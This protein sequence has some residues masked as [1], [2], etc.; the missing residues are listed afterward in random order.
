MKQQLEQLLNSAIGQ[1][2]SSDLLPGDFSPRFT[3]ERTRDPSHGDL[4]SNIALVSA[5]AAGNNPRQMA[6]FIVQAI[7]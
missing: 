7:P 5:K 6:E 4:A 2:K 3:I 1:L